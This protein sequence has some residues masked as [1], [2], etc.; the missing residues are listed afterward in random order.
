MKHVTSNPNRTKYGF[1]LVEL[2]VVITI[3]AIITVMGVVNYGG[4]NRKARDGRRMADIEKIRIALEMYRQV[5]GIY[6]VD[7]G[8]LVTDFMSA[9]PTDPKTGED[10]FASTGNY[11]YEIGT[12]MEDVGSTNI[13][14]YPC[15]SN[16]CNYKVTNP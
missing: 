11:V 12:S 3:I 5:N 10:Y 16:S 2:I 7:T 9:L 13:A 14:S 1:T 6:P 8:D 15:G 4:T